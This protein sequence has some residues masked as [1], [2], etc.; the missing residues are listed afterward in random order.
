MGTRAKLYL[1]CAGLAGVLSLLLVPFEQLAPDTGLP[2]LVLRAVSM[3]QPAVLVIV[4][5]LLGNALA[6]RVG[7]DAPLVRA[8]AAGGAGASVFRRQAAPAALVAIAVAVLLMAYSSVV[9]PRIIEQ[10]GSEP[11]AHFV[12][13]GQ[14][15][16]TKLLYGGITEELLTRWGLM[17][18]FA[19]I[20]WRVAGKPA[21][22][23][24][25][26]FWLAIVL[27]ALL[28]AA[29]HLPLLFALVDAPPRWV[30]AAV[31]VGNTLPGLLFG[32]LFWRRGIEAA[33]MAH[34][35]AHLLYV[36]G[37]QLR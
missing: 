7:L 28:F 33:I 1:I 3:I 9:V 20:G 8:W 32:W 19:W 13:V 22:I 35:A 4:F 26:I 12:E 23:P 2:P 5:V 18:A 15:L 30:V 6:P 27:S 34:A 16:V 21:E 10:P 31:M 37:D 11:F 29:G 25:T 36:A 14:P 17:S 24:R